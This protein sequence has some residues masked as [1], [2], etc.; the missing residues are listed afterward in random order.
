[1]TRPVAVV[2]GAA[3]LLLVTL[4]IPRS[5][6]ADLDLW[7]GD[8][9]GVEARFNI[10]SGCL[11]QQA[12]VTAQGSLEYVKS[13]VVRED[14]MVF[15]EVSEFDTCTNRYNYLRRFQNQQVPAEVF[16]LDPSLATAQL[17]GN[18]TVCN[19]TPNDGECR[20]L[21]IN[22]T[23]RPVTNV[24]TQTFAHHSRLNPPETKAEHLTLRSV[25]ADVVG[26]ITDG[27]TE[28]AAIATTGIVVIQH[29]G[30]IAVTPG[31]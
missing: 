25:V 31:N 4:F 3:L 17:K 22:L 7:R 15:V 23:W 5:H 24:D 19:L 26:S 30:I 10:M 27:V 9:T 29:E 8:Y 20:V 12:L 11:L 14:T 28:Y 18:L 6:A 21:S 2:T 13:A 1:M 16:V